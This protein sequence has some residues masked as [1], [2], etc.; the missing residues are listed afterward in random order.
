MKE[1]SFYGQVDAPH[2]HGYFR[3][4]RGEFR[5]IPKNGRTILEGRT[6]YEMDIFPGWYWQI[7]ARWFI[8]KIHLRVLDHI[9]KLSENASPI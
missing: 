3:S 2:L 7:Y 1:F 9:K 5:L 8:H 4:K 6:W